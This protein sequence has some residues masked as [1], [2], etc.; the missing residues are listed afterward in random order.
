MTHEKD[1]NE[2]GLQN[3]RQ[4]REW[5]EVFV[6]HIHDKRLICRV[7]IELLQFNNKDSNLKI[8]EGF[9]QTFLQRG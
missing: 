2:Y 5:E 4:A 6:N 9:E 7:H 8:Y 1:K 3:T